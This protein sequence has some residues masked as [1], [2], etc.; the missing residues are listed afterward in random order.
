MHIELD[1]TIV[2]EMDGIAG[3]RRPS[4]FVREPILALFAA[5]VPARRA[6][7]IDPAVRLRQE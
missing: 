3:L 1:D 5:D 7:S 4:A 6:N 2:T